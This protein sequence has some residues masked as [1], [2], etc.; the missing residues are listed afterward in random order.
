MGIVSRRVVTRMGLTST[1]EVDVRR[2]IRVDMPDGVTL[3]TNLYEPR[4][5]ERSPT[6]LVRSPYGRSVFG[7]SIGAPFASQGY[8]VVI[9]SCRG[10]AGSGGVFDPHHDERADGLATIA[11]I[12]RQ[13]WFDGSIVTYGMS[14]LGY[15]QWAVAASA[16]PE[17][18]AMAMQ[19]TMSD[20]SQMTYAGNSLMLENAAS[21]T[22]LVTTQRRRFGA[23]SLMWQQ[24]TKRPALRGEKW[25]TLPLASLD[26]VA[27]GERVAFWQDWMAHASADDPWWEPMNFHRT[28]P[29]IGRPITFVAGWHDIFT[30][31]SLR[32]FAALQ[33]AGAPVRITIGPWCHTDRAMASVVV[34]EAL[35]W[36]AVHLAQQPDSGEAPVK[37]YLQGTD[38]WRFHDA[39]P[40]TEAVDTTWY[41][42]PAG[43]L[44]E[45]APAESP[46]DTYRYDPADPTPSVGGPALMS[47]SVRVDNRS[48]EARGDVVCYTSPPLTQVVDVVGVPVATL[49]VASTAA[50]ADFFVRLCDVDEAGVSRNVCDGLQ[51]VSVEPS[52]APQAIRVELWPTAY[53]FKP[54]HRIRVQVS[55][56]A[57]PRWARNLGTGESLGTGTTMRVADQYIHHSPA[58][59]SAITLPVIPA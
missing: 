2:K 47:G 17:V 3:L 12:T 28:I 9:Q 35:D 50:S 10:T 21:W 46:P 44:A 48:L 38:E 11:W 24:V 8:R 39:W 31:W 25:R 45:G 15:T 36:F 40:P 6:V 18:K 42:H 43:R 32:D 55:S 19:V 49:H 30:P 56:G 13:P 1:H 33:R 58:T 4:G 16:G 54:G 27:T 23:V 26:E 41:L 51:R 14:Y 22:H 5:L 34:R 57:F 52:G 29:G 7:L 59:P 53:R 37:L 20:F